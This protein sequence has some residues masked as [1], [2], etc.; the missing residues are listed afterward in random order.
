MSTSK[1][2]ATDKL[3]DDVGLNILYELQ[4]NARISFSELG[5][6]VGL[7]S[8]AV[9]ERVRRME[10][11]GIITG[12]H[13][14]VNHNKLGKSI[15]VYVR[16]DAAD[17]NTQPLRR[18][19]AEMPS[20]LECHFITGTDDILIKACFDSVTDMEETLMQFTKY[21]EITTSLVLSSSVTRR[22]LR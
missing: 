14:H 18:F 11:A 10:D 1:G 3:L 6:R 12:Y 7:T 17:S 20:V 5:R 2:E 4:E 13:A 9:A 22:S 21:G 8:P 19:V 16:I 15:T